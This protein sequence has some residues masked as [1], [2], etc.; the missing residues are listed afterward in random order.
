[1]KSTS[2]DDVT[3]RGENEAPPRYADV[4]PYVD[5]VTRSL[6]W[7]LGIAA[8]AGP[9]RR[10]DRPLSRFVQFAAD[11]ARL[12]VALVRFPLPVQRFDA[13]AAGGRPSFAALAR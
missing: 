1:M 12:Q 4:K 11:R 8:P 5:A 2:A 3:N 9:G 13:L 7:L 6:D 10:N